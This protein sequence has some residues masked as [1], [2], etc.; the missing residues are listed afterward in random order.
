MKNLSILENKLKIKFKNKN[1]L[2]QALIHRSYLNEHPEEKLKDNERLEFLGDALLEMI[3]SEY[4][5]KK[6]KEEKEEELTLYRASLI[7]TENL[8][9]LAFKLGLNDFLYLS[10][11]EEKSF[12]KGRKV[13]LANTFEALIAAIY[14]DQGF[15]KT[16]EFI[17]KNLLKNIPKKIEKDLYKDPKTKIQEIAQAKY[18]ITPTYKILKEEGPP[19]NKKFTVGLFL[20]DKLISEGEGSSKYEAELEAALKG[21]TKI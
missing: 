1:L 7:N 4:L 10:K 17:I 19:H 13:I 11:G 5:F 2:K 9:N 6:F 8:S 14:L 3:V 15:K 18:K 21:L 16:K 12:G 20:N